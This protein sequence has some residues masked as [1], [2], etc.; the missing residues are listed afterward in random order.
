M[1]VKTSRLL[2]HF[3]VFSHVNVTLLCFY[4]GIPVTGSI[5]ILVTMFSTHA[6]SYW[7]G[8]IELCSVTGRRRE[9]LKAALSLGDN[10]AMRELVKDGE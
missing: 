2:T 5:N 6:C 1:T 4:T 7:C 3:T 10:S 8:Y 9:G